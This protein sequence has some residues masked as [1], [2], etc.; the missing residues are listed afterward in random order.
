MIRELTKEEII[1]AC[2]EQQIALLEC[3]EADQAE[4]EAKRKKTKAHKRLSLARD[5]VRSINFPTQF[6]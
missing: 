4:V 2:E 5:V 3:L 6:N 1:K